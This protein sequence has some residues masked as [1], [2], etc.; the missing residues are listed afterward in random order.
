MT[1]ESLKPFLNLPNATATDLKVHSAQKSNAKRCLVVLGCILIVAVCG[2]LIGVQ[3]WHLGQ[4]AAL[5][6]EVDD[7]K[8]QLQQY[9]RAG[10]FNDY[11]FDNELLANADEYDEPDLDFEF[12]SER[13]ASELLESGLAS[14]GMLDEDDDEE[15]TGRDY[16]RTGDEQGRSEDDEDANGDD[17]EYDGDDGTLYDTEDIS[18]TVAGAGAKRRA[19]SISGVTRQGVPIV[20]EPYVPRRNR[21]R[22]PHR[23]FEQLL[24][25][26]VEVVT[27]PTSGD[28]F[29]WDEGSRSTQAAQRTTSSQQETYGSI[30]IR[31][32]PQE[33]HH[34]RHHYAA[35]TPVPSYTSPA[36]PLYY[37]HNEL[38]TGNPTKAPAQ[39][40]NRRSRVQSTNSRNMQEKLQQQ[41]GFHKVIS[42]PGTNK[43]EL[44]R[45][46]GAHVR[47]RNLKAVPSNTSDPVA[48]GV[49]F[50]KQY[51]HDVRHQHKRHTHWSSKGS[52]NQPAIDSK[53]FRFED[54]YLIVKEPGLYYIYAQITYDNQHDTNGFKVLVRD[55]V[56]LSCTVH[57]RGANTNTCFTAG[58]V[59]VEYTETRIHVEDV[60]PHRHHVMYPEKTFFGAFKVGRLPQS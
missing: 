17:E 19:R 43:Q 59:K 5:Q 49:H 3:I 4:T 42:N 14:S 32:F 23:I 24:Q 60:D 37:P 39:I 20:D 58:L 6:R 22:Q 48:K 33:S 51:S 52:A 15:A 25:R 53:T 47:R 12:P 26:P 7:L 13:E 35:S 34:R 54:D 55:Q 56:H 16:T 21:T 57:S 28:M 40:I 9:N 30:S 41:A 1:A 11:E 50:V 8:L 45:A 29:R 36:S 27:P 10:E 46:R 44:V 38:N 18:V 2:T 31:P